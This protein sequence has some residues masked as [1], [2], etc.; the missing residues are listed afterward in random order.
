MSLVDVAW[1]VMDCIEL[2]AGVVEIWLGEVGR[3]VD[4]V[5]VEMGLEVGRIDEESVAVVVGPKAA[6]ELVIVADVA[7]VRKTES[8]E[9]K[10]Q[11]VILR[12]SSFS[13]FSKLCLEDR[14][15]AGKRRSPA[16]CNLPPKK[17][18]AL[19]CLGCRGFDQ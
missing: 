9:E 15:L 8:H 12:E 6:E 5:E 13:Q 1:L 4:A 3:D 11:A 19:P 10:V 14:S 16:G 2:V 7:C 18:A 17:G